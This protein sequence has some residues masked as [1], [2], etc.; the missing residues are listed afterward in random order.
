MSERAGLHSC[1]SVKWFKLRRGEIGVPLASSPWP[2]AVAGEP[3]FASLRC[4]PSQNIGP[5]L[6][7]SAKSSL[8]V[9]HLRTQCAPE[10]LLKGVKRAGEGIMVSPAHP[11]CLKTTFGGGHPR[12]CLTKLRRGPARDPSEQG[13]RARPSDCFRSEAR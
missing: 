13:D 6:S 2:R 8:P 9:N 3:A 12:R 10:A 4:L 5:S 11:M 7:L 1:Q